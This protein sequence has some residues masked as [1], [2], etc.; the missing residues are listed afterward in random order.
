MTTLPAW[1]S[2]AEPLR[3]VLHATPADVGLHFTLTDQPSAVASQPLATEG[4]LPPLSRL[5]LQA[6]ARRLPPAAI[7][8]EIRGQLDRFEDAWGSSPDYIDGHQHVH[9]LP[10]VREPLLDEIERRYPRGSVW[11]RNCAE[12]PSRAWARRVAVG[13]A[14]LLFV[15]GRRFAVMARERGHAVNDGFSGLHDF[16]ERVPFRQLMQAFLSNLGPRP[17][18]HVHPGHVDAELIAIDPLT[19]PRESEFAYL[20]SDEFTEDLAAAGVKLGR[21]RELDPA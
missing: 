3:S 17:L 2:V 6:E 1:T 12:S 19:T 21:F 18:I 11:L 9:V 7:R 10:G 13:K 14:W 4:R 8:D 20:A 15:L 5:L 16:S